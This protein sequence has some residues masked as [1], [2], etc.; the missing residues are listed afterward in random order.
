MTS[1]SVASL[2][3]RLLWQQRPHLS[4]TSLFSNNSTTAPASNTLPA[5]PEPT[6]RVILTDESSTHPPSRSPSPATRFHT[7][8]SSSHTFTNS[9]IRVASS[10]PIL[11]SS[12]YRRGTPSPLPDASKITD[13][14]AAMTDQG[15]AVQALKDATRISE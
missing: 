9:P 4:E 11:S 14:I 2:D 1:A 13:V 3:S 10:L 15:H 8:I 5:D 7:D 12:N 6:H